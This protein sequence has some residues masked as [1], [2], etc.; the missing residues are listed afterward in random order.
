MV[1]AARAGRPARRSLSG[2][3][4]SDAGRHQEDE[5]HQHAAASHTQAAHPKLI[6]HVLTTSTNLLSNDVG[7]TALLSWTVADPEAHTGRRG[8]CTSP[9]YVGARPRAE[10]LDTPRKVQTANVLHADKRTR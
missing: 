5:R 7:A 1:R 10:A 8:G 6:R 3:R 2:E 9:R 4:E